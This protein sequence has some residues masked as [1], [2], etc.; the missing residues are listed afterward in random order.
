MADKNNN[1][2]ANKMISELSKK[3]GMSEQQLSNA[4]KKGEINSIIQ[5]LQKTDKNQ[6]RQLESILSNP[7]KAKKLLESPQ[8]QALLKM[9]GGE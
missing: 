3:L 2:N 7:E 1:N 8:A 6:A 5:N 9:F 4:A